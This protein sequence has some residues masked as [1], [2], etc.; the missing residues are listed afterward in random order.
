[1]TKI[2]TTTVDIRRSELTTVSATVPAWELPILQALH[3]RTNV[4]VTG[5]GTKDVETLPETETEFERLTARYGRERREDGSLGMPLCEAVY[6]Q[7]QP[8]I[9][10]L[11][12]NI[13]AATIS[14]GG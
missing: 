12:R 9:M 3:G 1:M 8:G 11:Q 13:D 2:K 5:Q 6:G 14:A 10:N 4:Q 7:F